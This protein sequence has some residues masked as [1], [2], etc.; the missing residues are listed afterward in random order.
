[1]SPGLRTRTETIMARVSG[2]IRNAVLQPK[3]SAEDD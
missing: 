2:A 1:M 3:T